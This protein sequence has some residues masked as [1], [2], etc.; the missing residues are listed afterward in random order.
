LPTLG[1]LL[2]NYKRE[3]PKYLQFGLID[4]IEDIYAMNFQAIIE[5]LEFEKE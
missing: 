5:Q 2:N 1:C 3:S 4:I